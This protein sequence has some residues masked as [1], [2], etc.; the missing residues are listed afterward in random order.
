MEPFHHTPEQEVSPDT[1][2]SRLERWRRRRDRERVRR[3]QSQPHP[4]VPEATAHPVVRQEQSEPEEE[5]ETTPEPRRRR[6]ARILGRAV[7]AVS[8]KPELPP[9]PSVVSV[10][11]QS[12]YILPLE[13]AIKLGE[14]VKTQDQAALHTVEG[15]REQVLHSL[16]GETP[17]ERQQD[18]IQ[19]RELDRAG[20]ELER[21]QEDLQ[22]A[23]GEGWDTIA[24]HQAFEGG[25]LRPI[26]PID[27]A[28]DP[29]YQF[30]QVKHA[31]S[32]H[33]KVESAGSQASA[34]RSAAV[35]GAVVGGA[36]Y[37][38]TRSVG[39]EVHEV[40]QEQKSMRA[41]IRQQEQEIAANERT[42]RELRARPEIAAARPERREMARSVVRLVERQVDLSG[43]SAERIHREVQKSAERPITRVATPEKA[44]PRKEKPVEE[45]YEAAYDRPRPA[46]FE[47]AAT[48]P[49]L[50]RMLNVSTAE[51][52][53]APTERELSDR[54]E[55]Q[56]GLANMKKTVRAS[57]KALL[58]SQALGRTDD[59]SVMSEDGLQSG[60]PTLPRPQA[61]K[62]LTPT[63]THITGWVYVILVV[64]LA[65][66]ILFILKNI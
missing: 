43:Q 46:E 20:A 25:E 58:G 24:A 33:K 17:S 6:W 36:A 48:R 14:E 31:E 56:P 59:T 5:K 55:R 51:L 27:V 28:R 54:A 49:M 44:T 3:A 41:Q 60:S 29:S 11:R 64:A 32:L 50:E 13:R 47:K 37:L 34:A 1:A 18:I 39:R 42:I 63:Q 10:E 8:S 57:E 12:R 53:K 30:R 9:Q 26:Q 22:D 65:M 2:R 62:D 16:P 35:I 15:A 23:L 4:H 45:I 61:H 21:A 19:A 7:E 38:R 52:P 66:G 40:Q